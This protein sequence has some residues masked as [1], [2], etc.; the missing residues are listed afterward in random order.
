L[1]GF[2]G[3]LG[4][5]GLCAFTN[6]PRRSA[7]LRALNKQ[8]G[9]V[10]DM[11]VAVGGVELFESLA[12]RVSACF[13][14][15]ADEEPENSAFVQISETT[16]GHKDEIAASRSNPP[17]FSGWFFS[18]SPSLS[19]MEHPDYDIWLLKCAD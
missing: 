19:A 14:R 6:V 8:T 4:V 16:A 12:L 13:D 10:Q 9:R 15:P 3:L 5:L 18:S 2:F 1:R 7:L 11:D 17:V